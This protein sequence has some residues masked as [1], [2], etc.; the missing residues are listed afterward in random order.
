MLQRALRKTTPKTGVRKK[1]PKSEKCPKMPP[2]S[3]QKCSK[4]TPESGFATESANG[5]SIHYL[6]C[7]QHQEILKFCTV[8]LQ[9]QSKV[10]ANITS[11]K[12]ALNSSQKVNNVLP[13][14]SPKSSKHVPQ[15]YDPPWASLVGSAFVASLRQKVALWHP[16]VRTCFQIYQ[17]ELRTQP[18]L[19]KKLQESS[20]KTIEY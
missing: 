5:R 6:L 2:K 9:N 16:W 1:R 15:S 17:I 20:N 19:N 12:S 3:P 4:K 11:Q 13:A 18:K 8:V 10:E 7:R 14:G